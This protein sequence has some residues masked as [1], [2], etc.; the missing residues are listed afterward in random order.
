VANGR[1]TRGE[2]ISLCPFGDDFWSRGLAWY[3]DPEIIA[4]TSDDQ[5]QLTD[6]EFRR[7]IE[8][9]LTAEHS[10]VF[11][12]RDESGDP[13]GIGILR[14]VDPVHRG[15]ELHIT[16][17][18][19]RCWD[20]GYGGDAIATMRDYAF[21]VEHCH[22]VISTPFAKNPRM[23]R[24]LEKCGFEHEGVLRDALLQGDFFI[25]VVLM[26]TINPAD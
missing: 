22:K 11:G 4:L 13:I 24:C 7:S 26:G 6:D 8:G 5:S 20:R 15:C 2:R 16:I 10:V 19:R 14:N 21:Q 3:N 17:G 12:I 9:D 23:I 18:E 1:E 25:D